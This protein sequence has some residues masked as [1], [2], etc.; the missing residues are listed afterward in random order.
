MRNGDLENSGTDLVV[1]VFCRVAVPGSR[2]L[3]IGGQACILRELP[4]GAGG[5]GCSPRLPGLEALP[6]EAVALCQ[7]GQALQRRRRRPEV[8]AASK[9]QPENKA[10]STCLNSLCV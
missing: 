1:R 2:L 6:L 4:V 8:K 5:E 9:P 10:S 3:V 7:G